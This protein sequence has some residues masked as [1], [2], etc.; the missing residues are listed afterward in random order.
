[1]NEPSPRRPDWVPIA[2]AASVATALF[3]AAWGTLHYGFYQREKIEDT[4]LYQAYGD[5]IVGGAVPYRDVAVEYPPAALPAFV[6]PSLVAAE[7]DLAAYRGVFEALMAVCGALAAALIGFM[8]VRAGGGLVRVTLGIALFGLA[9]LALGSVVLSR[10]DLWPVALVAAALAALVAERPRLGLGLLGLATAAKVYPAVLIPL[11]VTYVW[12][13][14]GHGEALRCLALTLGVIAVIVV[15]FVAL[16]PDGV[17]DTVVRQATR[18]LQIESLGASLLLVAYQ[19]FHTPLA[20]R[21]SHGS[22][23]LVGTAPDILEPLATGVLAVALLGSWI[24]FARGPA[25]T[26][27]LL[28]YGAAVVCVFVAF[29]KVLS[30]QFLIWLVPLVALVP[31]RRGVAAG[32]LVLLALALTQ[33]WFPYRYWELALRF[34][35]LASWLVFAR[36]VVLVGLAAVLALPARARPSPS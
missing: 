2:L 15:P 11:A 9:P 4:A 16:A 25:E 18:P 7:G 30:P 20:M 28:R 3:L 6:V 36:D 8:L 26:A 23:N 12:K 5:A 31:G 1:M 32:A 27:R 13:R 19:V 17:W 24:A 14:R 10:F 35:P 21:S 22:Q 33:L 29:G 34:D